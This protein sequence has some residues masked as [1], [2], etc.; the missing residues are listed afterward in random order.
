MVT[1]IALL[2]THSTYHNDRRMSG[3]PETPKP[4]H[5]LRPNPARF[6]EQVREVARDTRNV[7]WSSHSRDRMSERGISNTMALRVI[8]EGRLSGDIEP[9]QKTGEWKA[10]FVRQIPGRREAGVVFLLIHNG[11]IFVKTVEWED[12]R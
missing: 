1:G 6:A 2:T 9:G 4:V 8:R 3:K 12:T 11:S 7:K 5:A 10:K